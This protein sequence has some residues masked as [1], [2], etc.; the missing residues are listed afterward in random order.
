MI[1]GIFRHIG[2]H[3]AFCQGGF[4]CL[5]APPLCVQSTAGGFH[6]QKGRR[7]PVEVRGTG[8]DRM[9]IPFEFA[10]HSVYKS[11]RD[12]LRKGKAR[13]YRTTAGAAISF[14]FENQAG[15][16]KQGGG[17]RVFRRAINYP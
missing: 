6:P 1:K 10:S 5:L 15:H 13:S 16:E 4:Q 3:P 14:L 12:K 8:A 9:K 17:S 2:P 11:P 7:R